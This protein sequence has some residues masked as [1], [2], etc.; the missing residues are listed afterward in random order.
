MSTAESPTAQAPTV[1]SPTASSPVLPGAGH[2]SPRP[3]APSQTP[4]KSPG[5]VASA[6]AERTPA[7]PDGR[8]PLRWDRQTGA[9]HWGDEVIRRVRVSQAGNIVRILDAFE[10]QKWP[11]QVDQPLG[12]QADRKTLFAAC[13]SLNESLGRIRFR[14]AGDGVEWFVVDRAAPQ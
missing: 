7:E 1:S 2:S 4:G 12:E 8:P 6:E 13:N 10:S 5:G 11:K 14:V 3:A 9:L